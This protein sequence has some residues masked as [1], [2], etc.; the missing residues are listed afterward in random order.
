[1]KKTNFKIEIINKYLRRNNLSK[2]KFCKMCKISNS[3]LR[4]IYEQNTGVYLSTIYKIT[5]IL[6]INLYE[7]FE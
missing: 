7:I 4:N 1:M 5:H 3:S 6:E 2:N